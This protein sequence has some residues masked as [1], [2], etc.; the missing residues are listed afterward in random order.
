MS[1][2]LD[3]AIVIGFLAINLIVGLNKGKD[4]KNI[5]DYALGGRN[6][7]TATLT[8]TLIA[9]WLGGDNL[10]LYL[11]ET[12]KQGL[13]FILS[14]FAA[15][16]SFLI[17]GHF[18]A[19]RM[20]EFMGSLSIAEAMG[21]LFGRNIRVISALVGLIAL[22]TLV[23]M[24]FKILSE[25]LGHFV[26]IP[27]NYVM[28][29][30]ASV[31]IL[32]SSLG[33][34]RSVTFTDVIQFFTFGTVI[35]VLTMVI[36]NSI[37]NPVE[38]I[39]LIEENPIFS[40]SALLD[41]NSPRFWSFV[42]LFL[43]F[44]IPGFDPSIFQ[45]ISM[46]SNLSQL[47]KAFTAAA[48]IVLVVQL[49]ISWVS[50]LILTKNP[51]LDSNNL[52]GYIIENYTYTGLKGLLVI[53]IIA[54]IM[55]TA[56]SCINAG[57]VMMSHDI[58]RV[59]GI[60]EPKNELLLSRISAVIIGA[61]ALVLATSFENLF[62]LFLLGYSFYMPIV[63]VPFTMAILGFRSSS[64]SV[65]IGMIAALTIVIVFYF[66]K[67]ADSLIPAMIANAVFL[68]GSHY[69]L[70][71]PGGW[72]GIKDNRELLAVRAERRKRYAN[73]LESIKNFSFLQFCKNNSPRQESSY[74]FF[75]VFSI[76]AV[77]STMYSMPQ[78]IR[79]EYH[80]LLEIIYHSILFISTAFLTYP[81]WPQTFRN[82]NFIAIFWILGLFYTISFVGTLQIVISNF[83]EFQ[84]MVFLI[85]M[86]VLSMFVR[87][88]ASLIIMLFG[89]ISGLQFFKWYYDVS[90]INT[91]FGSLEFKVM[92]ALLLVSSVLLAFL[93]P[94]Q[95]YIKETEDKVEVL[96]DEVHHLED[97]VDNLV[98]QV[99]HYSERVADQQ[100]EIERLGATAQRILNN[101]NHEL[102]LPVGNVMNFAEMLN[103]GLEKYSKEQLKMLSD[104]VYKN[105]TRLSTMILNML[106]LATLDVKKVNL[107]KQL[108]NFSELALD[109]IQTCRK[110]YLQGKQIDFEMA[111]EP[112]IMITVDPN[113]MRQ[114]IDNLVINAI[115]YS[116]NGTIKISLLKKNNMV[117]FTITDQGISIPKEE[118]YDIFTPFKMGSKTISKAEGRGVGLALCKSS[119][120]AHGGV[121]KAESTGIMGAT[122]RFLLPR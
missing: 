86:V 6:F 51:D 106:D 102:R 29:L 113:Y 40:F 98:S 36:W 118:L 116:T 73:L 84:L 16:G 21:N 82:E 8:A 58:C 97:E 87:W 75:G 41:P 57:S 33:G 34:I 120:E 32:Y 104:E 30:S 53:G 37:E 55:S 43:I 17:I 119:V 81:I 47:K 91:E 63:T 31:V 54:M 13:F 83:G 110:I 108:I 100:K 12:Y 1:F 99:T 11:S 74:S 46:S 35:P 22:T 88:Q 72:V 25:L 80:Q 23:S 18:F 60:I 62:D 67:I 68:L 76:I 45:R 7:T 70:R 28:L 3:I 61:F 56:D 79:L 2:N 5:D 122:L 48:I 71:Q 105:S 49:L 42:S 38:T 65:M 69:T 78:D 109:R 90:S 14:S 4:V 77:F 52:L 39:K 121:I 93:K 115:S 10:A 95:E 20:T 114:T 117:E 66:L 101:V 89:V 19:P 85:S 107:Q 59:L 50:V 24:Q 27:K 9:T 44:L 15:L 94:Q 92:Y 112:E 96:E 103:S 64:K 111:I 26:S